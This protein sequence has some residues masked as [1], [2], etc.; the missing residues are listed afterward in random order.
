MFVRAWAAVR[1][2]WRWA[3]DGVSAVWMDERPSSYEDGDGFPEAAPTQALPRVEVPAVERPA[4]GHPLFPEGQRVHPPFAPQPTPCTHIAVRMQRVLV[5]A[6]WDPTLTASKLEWMLRDLHAEL[7][8]LVRAEQNQP[9]R[10]QRNQ[11]ATAAQRVLLDDALHGADPE[12]IVAQA[13]ASMV[14]RARHV[15]SPEDTGIGVIPRITEDMADP[16]EPAPV[17]PAPEPA[18]EVE[19]AEPWTSEELSALGNVDNEQAVAGTQVAA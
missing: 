4:P 5:D 10:Q 6:S 18:V 19:P 1:G 16:R 14:A 9:R 13:A 3:V 17:E 2:A 15:G 12:A 8:F 7:C 11:A